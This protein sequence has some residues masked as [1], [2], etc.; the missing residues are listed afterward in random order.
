M[1]WSLPTGAQLLERARNSSGAAA[2]DF[3]SGSELASLP[4][5]VMEVFADISRRWVLAGAAPEQFS[6][7]RMV[8]LPKEGKVDASLV[9]KKWL[10]FALSANCRVGLGVRR[11]P[12]CVHW[13]EQFL[14]EEVAVRNNVSAEQCVYELLDEW[15]E[16]RGVYWCRFHGLM[17]VWPSI[18]RRSSSQR[19]DCVDDQSSTMAFSSTKMSWA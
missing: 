2:V 14:P 10:T 4:L 18:S 8:L 19:M 12:E 17:C 15:T 9:T 1:T 5:G 6:E 16:R 3:W 11:V 7:C 13:I